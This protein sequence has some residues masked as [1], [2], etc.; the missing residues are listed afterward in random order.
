MGVVLLL[1]LEDFFRLKK[2]RKKKAK[3]VSC[4]FFL[5]TQ[6][7]SKANFI[8]AE[9]VLSSRS[10]KEGPAQFHHPKSMWT[11]PLSPTESAGQRCVSSASLF[12]SYFS[13]D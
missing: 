3:H 4:K 10:A 8:L 7:L 11:R 13:R 9:L 5:S 12:S 6:P 1:P 2:K